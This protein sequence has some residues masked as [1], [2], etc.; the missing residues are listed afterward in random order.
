VCPKGADSVALFLETR[1]PDIKDPK[2]EFI[3]KTLRC[4]QRQ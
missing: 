2:P 3:G 1:I 4:T